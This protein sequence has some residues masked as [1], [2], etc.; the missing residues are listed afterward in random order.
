MQTVKEVDL[1][2]IEYVPMNM[3]MKYVLL[4]YVHAEFA[5]QASCASVTH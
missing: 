2:H 5:H 3:Y 1:I 4:E